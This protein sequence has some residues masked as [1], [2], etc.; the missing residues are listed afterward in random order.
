MGKADYV[1]LVFE[2]RVEIKQDIRI[3]HLPPQTFG[4]FLNPSGDQFVGA[5]FHT[6]V[7]YPVILQIPFVPVPVFAFFFFDRMERVIIGFRVAKNGIV[8]FGE[9]F[10]FV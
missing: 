9:V 7:Q 1:I 5:G 2:L 3:R 4:Y 8:I 10:S 6:P